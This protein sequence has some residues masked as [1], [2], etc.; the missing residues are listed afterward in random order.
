MELVAYVSPHM[1]NTYKPVCLP[2]MYSQIHKNAVNVFVWII[3]SAMVIQARWRKLKDQVQTTCV[4]KVYLALAT[5]IVEWCVEEEDQT[6][7]WKQP[8]CD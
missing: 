4:Q 8:Y 5:T 2:C 3:L 7:F 6:V 1:N